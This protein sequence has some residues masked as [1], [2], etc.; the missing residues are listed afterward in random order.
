V[1]WKRIHVNNDN[2]DEARMNRVSILA[3]C[4]A[5]VLSALFAAGCAGSWSKNETTVV[6]DA[7]FV[8]P[9]QDLAWENDRIAFRVYGPALAAEVSNGVDVWSKRVSY[10][11]IAKWYAGD[12]ATGPAKRSYHVDHG[13]GADFFSVGR[14]LGC[15]GSS[16]REGDALH[17]PGVFASHRILSTGPDRAEFELTYPPVLFRGR[18]VRETRRIAL[19]AGEH[20]N[21]IDVTYDVEGEPIDI[22]FAI[23]LVKRKNVAAAS[24]PSGNWI[25]L[26]GPT[27]DDPV[28]GDLGMGAVLPGNVFRSVREDSTHL[29]LYGETRS[30]ETVTYYAG[31]GWSRSGFVTDRNGWEAYLAAWAH[32]LER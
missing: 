20:L 32:N 13:E 22:P 3:A 28:N 15:G 18:A 25:S 23:G 31:A 8:E 17:Q 16:I 10:P 12:T 24:S 4:S 7:R 29:L 30:G 5:M 2:D 27:N 19:L 11:V 9:R 21:R 26:F 14:T 6:T 1:T